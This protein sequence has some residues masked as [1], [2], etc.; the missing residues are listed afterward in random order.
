MKHKYF[1]LIN[2]A[3]SIVLAACQTNKSTDSQFLNET[4]AASA[5]TQANS[6]VKTWQLKGSALAVEVRGINEQGTAIEVLNVSLF[7]DDHNQLHTS[8]LNTS[9][10]HLNSPTVK[11]EH[12]VE[13]TDVFVFISTTLDGNGNVVSSQVEGDSGKITDNMQ[14]DLQGSLFIFGSNSLGAAQ[15]KWATNSVNYSHACVLGQGNCQTAKD[16]LMETTHDLL[17]ELEPSAN[18]ETNILVIYE[19]SPTLFTF[20]FSS[21]RTWGVLA[22]LFPVGVIISPYRKHKVIGTLILISAICLLV[23]CSS[24]GKKSIQQKSTHQAHIVDIELLDEIDGQQLE[25]EGLP[26]SSPVMTVVN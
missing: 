4:L 16:E 21:P 7:D 26:L 5:K 11:I 12:K 24:S 23:S 10:N 22:L 18:Q 25:I 6:P 19:L 8:D 2:I 1:F 9:S 13:T 14:S 20:D 15:A 17:H 3:L